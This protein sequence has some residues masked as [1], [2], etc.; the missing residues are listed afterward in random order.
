MS[1]VDVGTAFVRVLP[2]P[3]QFTAA[4]IVEVNAAVLKAQAAVKPIVVP[5]VTTGSLAGVVGGGAAAAAAV[6]AEV[7]AGAT[8]AAAVSAFELARSA[9]AVAVAELNQIKTQIAL[10]VAL[11]V[12]A[13]E[14]LVVA[15]A[16]ANLAQKTT[17][18]AL[19]VEKL[20]LAQAG[21]TAAAGRY[22]AAT[23]AAGTSTG[24]AARN[25]SI[26][27]GSLIGLTRVSGISALGLTVYSAAAVAVGLSLRAAISSAAKFESQM[28]TFQAVTKATDEQMKQVSATAV[29]LGADL[30]LPATSSSDAAVALTELSK[31]GLSVEDSLAAAKGVLQL[32]TIAGISAGQAAQ[33]SASQ[34]NA[35]GL[36]GDQAGRV[37]EL[38]ADASIAAQGEITDFG[39]GLSQAATAAAQAG[40]SVEDTTALLTQLGLAGIKGA[41]AGTSLRTFLLRLVPTTK[42][43]A[44]YTKA[45]GIELDKNAT[46]GSQ[47]P[48][49][50]EQYR[51]Q[52]IL[53]NPQ[54]QTLV[55]NQIFGQDAF[56]A[57]SVI[58]RQ[59]KDA[60]RALTG[61][62]EKTNA[63]QDLSIAKAAGLSGA[64]GSLKSQMETFGTQVG[65]LVAGPL[66]SFIRGLSEAFVDIGN[67]VT[68]LANLEAVQDIE[69]TVTIVLNAKVPGGKSVFEWLTL[70]NPVTGPVVGTKKLLDLFGGNAPSAKEILGP[71]VPK[72][73]FDKP[74]ARRNFQTPTEAELAFNSAEARRRRAIV[75]KQ[76]ADS[77]AATA[78][79]KGIP[80]PKDLQQAQV[81]AQIKNSL[82]AELAA[83]NKILK[84][85]EGK[86]NRLHEGTKAF[87]AVSKQ[88]ESAQAQRDSVQAE[89][90]SNFNSAASARKS[91]ADAAS[92]LAIK[93]AKA[94][95]AAQELLRRTIAD[96]QTQ[97]FSNLLARA[98]LTPSTEDNKKILSAEQTRLEAARK[99]AQKLADTA[100]L[101]KQK[102]AEAR[103]KVAKLDGEILGIKSQILNL[104]SGGAAG[105]GFSI[106]DLFKEALTQFNEFGSNVSSSPMTPGGVRG[107]LGGDIAR[108]I[109]TNPKVQ[110][111][112]KVVGI[113]GIDKNTA[114]AAKYM[115]FLYEYFTGNKAPSGTVPDDVVTPRGAGV[116][117]WTAAQA[118][119]FAKVRGN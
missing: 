25:A 75:A 35:F 60:L 41:D 22:S 7:L 11:G 66:E 65:L 17:A 81:D 105:G 71:E 86:L 56:R 103:L 43:A 114:D 40:V 9:N 55:L 37:T 46:I 73:F 2:M 90:D 27:Q 53:L 16:E 58:F 107:Q 47:L 67:I 72:G 69:K 1:S 99:A 52:L 119:A 10:N 33:L 50:I 30:S 88:V 62:F 93:N 32:A 113:E 14:A 26:A 49:V 15:L 68:A 83:D 100:G 38:L 5:V 84:F 8:S 54:Q 94:A 101:S 48:D 31:A 29:A 98:N 115:K 82:S 28:N 20:A 95:T 97:R 4:L 87:L 6:E 70:I 111:D 92:A 89:I 112:L 110:K 18:A 36:A 76:T 39:Q 23:A 80:I 91:K 117:H 19:A 108:N 102:L 96:I 63:A 45:L 118:K 51:K 77:A 21:G 13:D 85:F 109:I 44:Q 42:E 74:I 12:T 78:A 64:I 24:H 106:A 59:N 57:A 34:L 61:E 79:E 104:G 3:N 116:G